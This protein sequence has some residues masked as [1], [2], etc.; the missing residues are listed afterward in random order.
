MRKLFRIIL[1]AVTALATACMKA[2]SSLGRLLSG[3]GYTPPPPIPTMTAVDVRDEYEDG[4]EREV[5]AA[6]AR[7]SDIG[8]AVHQYAAAEDPGVRCAVDLAGLDYAQMD[9]LLSLKD[10]DLQ[11]M[12]AA[13]PRACELAVTGRRSGIIGLPAPKM[14]DAAHEITMHPVRSLLDDRIRA[15]RLGRDLTAA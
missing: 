11:K 4:Y 13:G 14:E 6:E 9:W 10:D 1:L 8:M 7:A 15:R 2:L 5:V 12:A 3:G